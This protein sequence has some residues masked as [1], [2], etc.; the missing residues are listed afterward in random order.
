MTMPLK[1]RLETGEFAI[2]VEMDPP[3]GVDATLMLKH[4][5]RV[6]GEVD[7][8]VV[9]EMSS[10]VMRMSALGGAML[11]QS[12]GMETVMQVNCRD[13]N[14]IAIQ[15]DL[16][17]A[18]ACGIGNI[19]AVSG[20]EPRFGDHP[21]ASAVYDIDLM[22][23]VKTTRGLVDG[24]DMAGIELAG[25]PEFMV[26]AT[27]D[28]GAGGDELEK[29]IESFQA[30]GAAGVDFFIAPA[31]FDPAA[32]DGFTSRIDLGQARILPTVLLLK[33]AGMARYVAR[34]F[35]NIHVPADTISRIQKAGD[36]TRECVLIAAETILTIKNAGFA[37]VVISP[38]GWEDQLPEIL[39]RI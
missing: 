3:K 5:G 15:A 19:M 11:L 7:A 37:G 26:G 25:A 8:F 17:A 23:L 22:D 27:V 14:R 20:E 16:L 36:R 34:N 30:K 2:L 1:R 39:D 6:K 38:I 21:E 10:A 9:P 24:K 33:S 13:R 28:P 4:A 31:L 35:P 32:V 18:G 12:K 29:E